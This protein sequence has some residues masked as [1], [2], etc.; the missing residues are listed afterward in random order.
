MRFDH[1]V[2]AVHDLDRAKADFEALGFTTFY[3]GSHAGGGTHNRL[4]VFED[5]SYLELMAPADPAALGGPPDAGGDFLHLLR[6]GEGFVGYALHSKHLDEAVHAMRESGIEVGDPNAGSR[7]R[8]DGQEI[9]WR[10]AAMPGT[11]SPMFITDTTPRVLRVPDDPEL[12]SH[13]NGATGCAGIAL[14]VADMKSS[15]ARYRAILGAAGHGEPSVVTA[16]SAAFGL[17]PTLI[18]L[19][20]PEGDA[21][22]GAQLS[23]RG[24]TPYRIRLY[25]KEE[26]RLG[27]LDP[28]RTHGARIELVPGL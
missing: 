17:G 10:M 7:T 16:S 27:V 1:A 24:D 15:V 18:T 8:P 23:K 13:A 28:A 12:T 21:G 20:T 4:I 6:T 11:I 2:L 25:S 9:A 19:A 5:G 14:V 3:G 26:S 22:L